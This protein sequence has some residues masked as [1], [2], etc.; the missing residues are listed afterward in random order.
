MAQTLHIARS[1]PTGEDFP[2][3]VAMKAFRR[4]VAHWGLGNEEAAAL[5]DVTPRT[6]ARMKKPD[7]SGRLSQDQMLRLS[8]LIGLY[9]A[10]HLYFSAPLADRWV[11][12]PNEGPL[13]Q[14][15]TPVAR[16]I[17][18]GLPAILET[19]GYV[20]ALRGGA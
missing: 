5:L 19:R 16:M 4:L 11:G 6:W 2:L 14:G 10:L 3:P 12:M 7:W 18:G 20:D 1:T 8:A 15:A 9:K 17:E 13:F